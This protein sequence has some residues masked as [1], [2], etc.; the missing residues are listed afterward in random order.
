MC[1]FISYSIKHCGK[2][3][4]VICSGGHHKN[5]PKRRASGQ[6]IFAWALHH[7][8]DGTQVGGASGLRHGL[9][10]LALPLAFFAFVAP[11]AK[12]QV[13]VALALVQLPAFFINEV[14][15]VPALKMDK[16]LPA[17][18]QRPDDLLYD[19]GNRGG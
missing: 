14:S 1:R 3:G 4:K 10:E 12:V 5:A 8:P 19:D 17:V 7:I 6:W 18:F 9:W 2:K 11:G 15:A 16:A 13:F